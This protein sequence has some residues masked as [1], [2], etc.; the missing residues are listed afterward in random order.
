[1]QHGDR[2]AR[3]ED[4][5]VWRSCAHCLDDPGDQTAFGASFA[6]LY[7]AAARYFDPGNPLV[8]NGKV[9]TSRLP[10]VVK[11]SECLAWRSDDE[12]RMRRLG[13]SFWTSVKSESV[14][15]KAF[16]SRGIRLAM[17]LVRKIN[18]ATGTEMRLE[19]L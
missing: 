16:H 9:D 3:A 2:C 8:N 6:G 19:D 10:K 13:R 14:V 7:V 5:P 15:T 11:H 17:R 1:M 18:L 4:E 12:I